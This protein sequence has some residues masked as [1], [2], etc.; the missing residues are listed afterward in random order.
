MLAH[1]H[2]TALLCRFASIPIAPS[3]LLCSPWIALVVLV[4]TPISYFMIGLSSSASVFFYHC[5][6]VF[7]ASC[8]YWCLGLLLASAMPAFE[9]AQAAAGL[10]SPLFFL[11]SG[12]WAP[13]SQIVPGAAWFCTIDPLAFLF[14]AIEPPH[15]YCEGPSCPTVTT[16]TNS[17][18]VTQVR[19]QQGRL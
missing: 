10:L 9:A 19:A 6:C 17:G 2:A 15:F 16:L 1:P 5:L 13:R 8:A 3:F 7:I 4:C 18:P 11:F 12:M 14:A